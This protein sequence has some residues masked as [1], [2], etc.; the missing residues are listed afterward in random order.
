MSSPTRT[1]LLCERDRQTTIKQH[2]MGGTEID[3]K[4]RWRCAKITFRYE[5]K[6]CIYIYIYISWEDHLFIALPLLRNVFM[7]LSVIIQCSVL[8]LRKESI[9]TCLQNCEKLLLVSICLMS[10]R[11]PDRL[12]VCTNSAPAGPIFMKFDI[13]V[14][15]VNLLR[16]L[17]FYYNITKCSGY[18][19]WILT[20]IYLS[21]FFLCRG[22]VSDKEVETLKNTF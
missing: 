20:Y 21:E 14:F 7:S 18:L 17:N 4:A 8:F 5:K 1:L 16:K 6:M 11:P 15:F 19:T 10:V 2:I 12:S 9:L 3:Y 13:W 22:N